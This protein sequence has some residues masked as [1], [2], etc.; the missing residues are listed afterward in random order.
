MSYVDPKINVKKNVGI[1]DIHHDGYYDR[2]DVIPSGR[3]N[4]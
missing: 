4:G 2:P 3:K 1:R